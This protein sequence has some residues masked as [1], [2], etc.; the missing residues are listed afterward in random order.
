MKD[1]LKKGDCHS[2]ITFRYDLVT[3]QVVNLV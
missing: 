2:G 1:M 3:I